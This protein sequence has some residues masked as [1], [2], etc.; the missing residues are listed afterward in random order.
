MLYNIKIRLTRVWYCCP[1]IIYSTIVN[2]VF[3]ALRGLN[4]TTLLPVHH[5]SSKA[6]PES[7]QVLAV[8]FKVN[9]EGYFFMSVDW[10]KSVNRLSGQ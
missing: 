5:V 4:A 6:F 2:V 3:L 10:C 9:N 8:L 7:G 1:S